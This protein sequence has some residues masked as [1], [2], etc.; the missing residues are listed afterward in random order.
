MRMNACVI[1]IL[2]LSFAPLLTAQTT[3]P[4]PTPHHEANFDAERN[5]HCDAD[6]HC[7]GDRHCYGH[8]DVNSD[9]NADAG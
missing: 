2:A 1:A 8:R 5:R 6:A 7:Y 9:G 4:P 3:P